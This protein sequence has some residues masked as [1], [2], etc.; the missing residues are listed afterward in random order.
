MT[1]RGRWGASNCLGPA[2]RSTDI[3][4]ILMCSSNMCCQRNAF[5]PGRSS[6]PQ[7]PGLSWL[8]HKCRFGPVLEHLC[9]N[10]SHMSLGEI[11]SKLKLTSTLILQVCGRRHPW[12]WSCSQIS[13]SNCRFWWHSSLCGPPGTHTTSCLCL[14]YANQG[15]AAQRGRWAWLWPGHRTWPRTRRSAASGC[16]GHCAALQAP[17]QPQFL[18]T[19]TT[20]LQESSL[21]I[22]ASL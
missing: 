8:E 13:C 21:L 11:L 14:S 1:K 17:F 6:P 2:P 22:Q 16:R 12:P 7:W 10:S 20:A 19:L 4:V 3:Q 18:A 9:L 15:C 5:C